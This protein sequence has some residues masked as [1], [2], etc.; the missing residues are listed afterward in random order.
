MRRLGVRLLGGLAIEGV[1]RAA[2]GTRKQRRLL[3]R[4]AVAR[5]AAVSVDELADDLWGDAQPASPRDQVAVLASRLRSALPEGAISWRHG[6]YALE[7]EWSDLDALIERSQEAARRAAEQQWAPAA[8]AAR[9][10]LALVRGEV[11]PEFAE[12]DWVV[13]ER[14]R[15]SQSIQRARLVLAEAELAV[16]DPRLAADVA[17]EALAASPYDEGALRLHLDACRAAHS[18][19]IGLATYAA[20]RARLADE[21]GVNPTPDTRAAFD[22]LLQSTGDQDP[23][24]APT[25][26]PPGRGRELALVARAIAAAERGAAS[27]IVLTGEPGIG[28]TRVLRAAAELDRPLVVWARC[29]ELG[30]VLPLQPIL[31]ALADVL[32]LRTPEELADLLA[33]DADLLAPLLGLHL[34]LSSPVLPDAGTGQLLLQAAVVR[35][36]ERLAGDGAVLLLV[37]DAHAA[38]AATVA[39]VTGLPRRASRVV[40]VLAARAGVGPRWPEGAVVELGPLDLE[41]VTQIVGTE[42]AAVLHA[43]SGGHPLLLSELV[44]HGVD[45]VPENL[46]ATFGAAADSAGRTGATVRAAS[47]V[48]PDLDLDVLAA[49][50]RRPAVEILDDL[51]DGVRCRLLVERTSGFAFRHALVREALAADVGP[52]RT[53]LLHR[54]TA[55]VLLGRKSG[56]PLVLADHARAGGLLDV[57]GEAFASAAAIA[58]AR[59]AHEEALRLAEEALGAD[60]AHAAAALHRARALLALGRYQETAAAAAAAAQLGAGVAALQVGGL[61]AHYLRNWPAATVLADRAAEGADTPEERAIALA[62]GGHA[63]HGAG[64]V[65]GADARFTAAGNALRG[66]GRTPSGWL[67]LLRH[68][69]GRSEETLEIT[70]ET[71]PEA[72]GLDQLALPLVRM[73]RGL[74]LAALGRSAEALD[75]FAAMDE[76]VDRLGVSRYAGRA[77]NCRGHVLRNLGLLERADDVNLRAREAA[78]RVG[79]D[80]A[81]A[82]AVLDL[83]EGRLRVGDLDAVERLL[84]EADAYSSGERPDGYQ[85]RQRLRADWLRGRLAL[86]AGD[87]DTAGE[88]AA[89]V[90][91]Q[92]QLRQATRYEAFGRVLALGVRVAE[93]TPPPPAHALR[94]I[95][96][97]SASAGMEQLWL[98]VD[99]A[100]CAHGD[101]REALLDRASEI[102]RQL[103]DD[104]PVDMRDDVR[105]HVAVLLDRLSRPG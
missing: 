79:V 13:V 99:L 92:A 103:I 101:L 20:F 91:E 42:R 40:A 24:P 14:E 94:A 18:P 74:S 19:A 55:R 2:L 35:L 105:R 83:A 102:G 33:D 96:T 41:A 36:L 30:R 62:I 64:D 5:G 100:T 16:G 31:D 59:H 22:R 12:A 11:L 38:D 68:H 57:A 90:R 51:E 75:C 85:W 29:D 27:L 60:P 23:E 3:A 93:G 77:D 87:V 37:D 71:G 70:S 73:S 54:E 72:T 95:D 39:L 61:A 76:V 80:E 89:E 10:A 28:K 4:L 47:V 44:A 25:D 88:L 6:G 86:A 67:A 56:D 49:V 8:E 50:L 98:T 46:R 97:L 9:A 104:S 7:A 15:A 52:T 82:H 21:L 65:A 53:A 17:R 1:D 32:R 58:A 69:Q 78:S 66:L 81:A 48:G 43:R 26:P 34:S 63:R 84:R 45:S